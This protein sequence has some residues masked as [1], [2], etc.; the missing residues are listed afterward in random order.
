MAG[1]FCVKAAFRKPNKIQVKYVFAKKVA[2]GTRP[3]REAA[4][5]VEDRASEQR[6]TVRGACSRNGLTC[7]LDKG[8]DDI[9]AHPVPPSP[10]LLLFPARKK[11]AS[12]YPA[13]R[14]KFLYGDTETPSV[15]L[16]TG[17]TPSAISGSATGKARRLSAPPQSGV[18]RML[19]LTAPSEREPYEELPQSPLRTEN[20]GL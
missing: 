19:S 8:A 18:A 3:R 11:K 7:S 4:H 13:L 6:K 20:T 1:I 10:F 15:D 2:N 5:P 14:D 12:Y 9:N 17:N 16:R